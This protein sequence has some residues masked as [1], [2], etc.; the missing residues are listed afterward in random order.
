VLEL[1]HAAAYKNAL[2]NSLYCPDYNIGKIT[3]DQMHSFVQSNFT[4]ERMVL[5]GLGVDH[6]SVK[7]IGQQ[8]LN[9]RSGKGGVCPKAVYHGGE[10]RH[11]TGSGLTH[12]MVAIEGPSITSADVTAFGVLQ[13]VLGVGQRVKRA[14]GNGSR[15]SH[16]IGKVTALPFDVSAFNVN[17]TDSGLFGIY[18]IAQANAA[19]DVVKAAVDQVADVAIGN[20]S[21]ADLSKAKNQLLADY[22][23][24]LESSDGLADSVLTQVISEETYSSPEVVSQKINAVSSEDVVTAAN[25]FMSGKKTLVSSGDMVNAPFLDDL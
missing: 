9:I 23:M 12:T 10:L 21:E 18:T 3:P 16:A 17:Y 1:L 19:K 14:S 22:L 4:S 5:V 2:S 25:K 11:Q 15:L 6:D 8:F 7:Q 13:H 20:L 24:S